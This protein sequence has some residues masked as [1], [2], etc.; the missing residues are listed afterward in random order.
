MI[1]GLAG[2]GAVGSAVKY[3]M[4]KLG[5]TVVPHDPRLNTKIED[6]LET[7]LCFI[8]V[9][10]PS[11]PDGSC[12]TSIV[13][14]VVAE[15]QSH[16]YQGIIAIKSTV[17]PGTTQALIEQYSNTRICFVPEFLRERCAST[18]F[19]ENH[20]ICIVGTTEEDVYNIVVEAHGRYPK[21]FF[22]LSPTE[23]ELCKYFNN[24]YNATLVTFANSFYEVTKACNADYSKIKD[25][26]VNRDHI[27]DR[28]LDCN[29]NFRGFCGV[30]LPKDMRAINHLIKEHNLNVEFFE[31][32]L[33]ENDKY[34]KT[35]FEGMRP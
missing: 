11:N 8:C 26:M 25:V 29:E 30:C 20:D 15:L 31:D 3:G 9:P 22:M 21:K 24:N 18:D 33:Q 10:T 27:F 35:A 7:E 12:N 32:V 34:K 1:I 2:V 16:N 17:K 13:E 14:Q 23:A 4:E 5:H 6:I 19:M 28:Y